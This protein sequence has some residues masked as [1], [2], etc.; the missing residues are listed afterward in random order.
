MSTRRQ[1]LG[2]GART[3][4]AAAATLA[5]TRLA[6]GGPW[7][8]ARPAVAGRLE[9][10]VTS[11]AD[12]VTSPPIAVALQPQGAALAAPTPTP[13]SAALPA[14]A[15]V[16]T[17]MARP[18][19][20][21]ALTTEAGQAGFR[22]TI[23][24]AENMG[25]ASFS[26]RFGDGPAATGSSVV[27]RP[28]SAEALEGL[29]TVSDDSGD[30][31]EI[32]LVRL[33]AYGTPSVLTTDL[34]NIGVQGHVNFDLPAAEGGI[35]TIPG[36]LKAIA[37]IKEMGM[38]LV[39]TD[40]IWEKINTA[41]GVFGWNNL[42]YADV[43]G[44]LAQNG[45]GSLAILKGTPL[46]CSSAPHLPYPGFWNVAPTD[47]R[48]YGEIVYRFVEHFGPTIKMIE[49]YQ[50][51]N[52]SL[53]WNFDAPGLAALQREG[54]LHAKYAN[55]DVCV[56]LTG[57][58]GV[59]ER[60]TRGD[61]GYWHYGPVLFE[62]PEQFL[63]RLYQASNG[64]AWWDTL[65]LHTYPDM[66]LFSPQTGFDLSRSIAFINSIKATMRAFGDTTPLSI[67]EI[68][69]STPRDQPPPQA[70]SQFLGQLIDT[71]RTHTAAPV[72][73]WYRL[74]EGPNVN[75]PDD[76]RGLATHD[77]ERLTPIGQTVKTYIAQH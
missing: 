58:V 40:W 72:L 35:T 44:L 64:R 38:N 49:V 56:G 55:P 73:I 5:A 76:R 52:V 4:L 50:E 62:Q 39:R 10:T 71:M 28:G 15:Q 47:A 30:L 32:P 77:L 31:A 74:N 19:P 8:P 42:H 66:D 61:D 25:G 43:L 20:I 37:R 60:A 45:L 29:L 2:I 54:F 11:L 59:P 3:A 34:P 23:Q 26:W 69:T 13:F 14:H 1:F 65:G 7:L 57:L 9:Y 75:S 36:V 70:V 68:G 18:T 41:P 51:P 27:V 33:V 16:Q 46:W 53:Y 48:L 22:L 12:G 17:S 24:R 67:T 21:A 6:Q 63:T